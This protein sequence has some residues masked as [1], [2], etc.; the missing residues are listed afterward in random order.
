VEPGLDDAEPLRE[1][2]ALG[3]ERVAIEQ[4]PK[5][6]DPDA[7]IA[8]HVA[9]HRL[10][11]RDESA[12]LKPT[13]RRLADAEQRRDVLLAVLPVAPGLSQQL[14]EGDVAV[15]LDLGNAGDVT[16]AAG[17]NRASTAVS[18]P[19]LYRAVTRCQPGNQTPL[20]M[21]MRSRFVRE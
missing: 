21:A 14:P 13:Q 11:V 17:I 8:G 1:R 9:L 5:L 6:G 3:L 10:I 4:G 12:Q 19:P 2:E 7:Q 15:R 16:A 20:R 18:P